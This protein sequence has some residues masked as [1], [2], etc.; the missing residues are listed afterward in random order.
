MKI[1]TVD[2]LAPL[3]RQLETLA[4]STHLNEYVFR[5][6]GNADWPLQ[7]TFSRYSTS[8]LPE[9][10]G[11]A[12]EHLITQYTDGLARIGDRRM[13]ELNRRGR[14]EL[15]RHSGVPSPLIDFTR[16]PFVALWFAFN[17]IRG[18]VD[19][20]KNV[21]IYA[22]DWNMTGAAFG[23]F[24]EKTGLEDRIR[25]KYGRP[26]IDMFRWETA[27]FFDEGYP[28]LLKFIPYAA[29]WNVK[30]NRQQGCFLYDGVD[31]ESL[32]EKNTEEILSK[33]KHFAISDS[34]LI[35]FIIPCSLA[36][37]VFQYLEIVGISGA[38]LFNDE[39]GV[40]ADVYNSFNHDVRS[41]S[42]DIKGE[43]INQI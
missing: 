4:L 19:K 39:Y 10:R 23:H 30:M 18:S 9:F 3:L 38:H 42:W 7:S 37:E 33:N 25:R 14:L 41:R 29:S 22:L 12:F 24:C 11:L 20:D 5:G 17:G 26:S 40:V 1:I 8:K 34:L 31:Y 43:G 27:S 16:S 35:K 2:A 36:R 13:V 28:D 15:A 21:A 32:D 6:Q